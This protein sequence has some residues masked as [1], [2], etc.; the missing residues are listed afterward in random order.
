MEARIKYYSIEGWYRCS[1]CGQ[2]YFKPGFK[3]CKVCNG[4]LEPYKPKA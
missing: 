4:K 1:R 3:Y 2:M